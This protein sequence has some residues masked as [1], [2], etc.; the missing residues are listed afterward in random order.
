MDALYEMFE[1]RI[2]PGSTILDIGCGSGRDSKHFSEKGY[3]V[4]AHDGSVAMVEQT[5]VF[6]GDR[7]ALARFD[8]FDPRVQFGKTIVFAGLWACASLLHVAEDD[9]VDV[10]HR[11]LNLL[12]LDGV[13]FMSFKRREVNHEK[14][15]RVFT[16]F[17]PDKLDRL[18][19]DIGNVVVEEYI[20]TSD[21][22][23]GREDEGWISVLVRRKQ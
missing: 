17:T 23:V 22:R 11:Y 4:Y 3:E 13:F 5:K 18:L 7:V 10:I 6:V 20:E 12:A 19:S 15:G 16:N 8:E 2:K 14:D 9:M 1:K 21:A